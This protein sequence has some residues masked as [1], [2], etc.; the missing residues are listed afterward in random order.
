MQA[1]PPG[2]W[3][4]QPGCPNIRSVPAFAAALSKRTGL[5]YG[6]GAEGCQPGIVPV[7]AS[8]TR[9]WYGAYYSGAVDAVGTM[10]ALDPSS[11]ELR[12]RRSFEYPL[13]SSAL[14]TA[15]GLVFTTTAD[16]SLH[17][18][19]DETLA[20]VWSQNLA[21]LTP[22]PPVTFLV[23]GKQRVAVVVGGNAMTGSLS[24]R[25]SEMSLTESL[26]VLLVLGIP[27]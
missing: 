15:G 1:H 7:R 19:N 2:L 11:G 24:Y 20:T 6:A 12:R 10:S 9:G 21:T 14:A 16:G 8:T 18:L 4:R 17:A 27:E 23:D 25:P 13:H 26:F 3:D 5:A 22:V